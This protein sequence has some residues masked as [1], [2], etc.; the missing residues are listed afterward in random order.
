MSGTRNRYY[1]PNPLKKE[2]GDCVVRALCKATGKDWDTVYRELYEIGMELKIMPNSKEAWKTYLR[3]HRFI[4]H[5]V[6]NKKGTKRPKVQ[7]F[8]RSHRTGTFV[9]SVANHVVTCEDG[10]YYDLD[11]FGRSSLYSYWEKPQETVADI[12]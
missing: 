12:K 6:S 4:E 10:Y 11:D 5:K 7:E 1:N 2:T 3:R 9:L 8:A